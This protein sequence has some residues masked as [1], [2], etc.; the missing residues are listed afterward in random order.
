MG[1][2]YWDSSFQQREGESIEIGELR[3]IIAVVE[4]KSLEHQRI[5]HENADSLRAGELAVGFAD[6]VKGS[7]HDLHHSGIVLR[8]A[9][10]LV[11]V[12]AFLV[13][14]LVYPF[15][16]RHYFVAVYVRV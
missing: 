10:F 2:S 9:D 3:V 11:A 12:R 5:A 16:P 1:D 6:V 15:W 7:D 14:T 4:R 13:K 8:Y